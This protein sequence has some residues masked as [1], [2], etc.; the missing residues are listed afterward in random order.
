ANTIA[1]K[2]N[3]LWNLPDDATNPDAGN[4][5]NLSLARQ[6]YGDARALFNAAGE[7]E[8]ARIIGQAIDQI[9]RETLSVT[10][11]NGHAAAAQEHH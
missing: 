1:N 6:Y 3:C 11:V 7:I 5:Q 8:K 2:A 9:E 4:R 10:P